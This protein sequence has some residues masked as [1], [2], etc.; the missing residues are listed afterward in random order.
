MQDG[1]GRRLSYGVTKSVAESAA[2]FNRDHGAIGLVDKAGNAKVDPPDSALYVIVS[3]GDDGLGA[4]SANGVLHTSCSGA[5]RDVENCRHDNAIFPVTHQMR[6]TVHG[7]DHLDDFATYDSDLNDNPLRAVSCTAGEFLTGFDPEGN[8]LCRNL[9][10]A[11]L[12]GEVAVGLNDDA[13]VLCRSLE[14]ACPNGQVMTGLGQA[15]WRFAAPRP[16]RVR[17][18]NPRAA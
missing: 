6:N 2:G 18:I 13:E 12:S 10:S 4:H 3:H 7:S 17:A 5:G 16:V 8:L 11:C 14:T 15:A 1:Y 9:A